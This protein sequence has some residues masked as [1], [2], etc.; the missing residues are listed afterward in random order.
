[1]Y[2]LEITPACEEHLDT[3]E[4]RTRELLSDKVEI[5]LKNPAHF[6]SLQHPEKNLF[7]IR[8]TVRRREKRLVYSV[9]NDTVILLCNRKRED[10]GK[11]L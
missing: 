11:Y 10:I 3:L 2:K 9:E 8:F 5:A 1:M 4:L 7:A 6:K